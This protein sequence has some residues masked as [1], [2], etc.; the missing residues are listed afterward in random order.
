MRTEPKKNWRGFT[1]HMCKLL[2][3]VIDEFPELKD[4]LTRQD[5]ICHEDGTTVIRSWQNFSYCEM[6]FASREGS[7]FYNLLAWT[8]TLEDDVFQIVIVFNRQWLLLDDE[9]QKDILRHEVLH[10]KMDKSDT[11]ID[12]I[13][14]C[15]RRKLF[16]ND[17]SWRIY[18]GYH[19]EENG[20]DEELFN[21]I[22]P[23]GMK[24]WS[25]YLEPLLK[26]DE[27]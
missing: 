17:K 12:F 27:K 3:E 24:Y 14:E 9:E 7:H 6:P 23:G 25:S 5:F 11:D 21:S 10:Y 19:M 18:F 4:R 26:G 20:F 8:K 16:I 22:F 1:S 2:G 15:I 13:E